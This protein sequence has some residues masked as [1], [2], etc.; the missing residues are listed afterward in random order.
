ME[1]GEDSIAQGCSEVYI[2]L[3]KYG[4]LGILGI[5]LVV[6]VFKGLIAIIKAIFTT[7]IVFLFFW[8]GILAFLG[9]TF[10]RKLKE[11]KSDNGAESDEDNI[12]KRL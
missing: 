2:D 8:L 11:F 12:N 7:P 4:V 5:G 9:I 1:S 3:I 6:V 10:Y